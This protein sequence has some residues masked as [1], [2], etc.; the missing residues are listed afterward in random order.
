MI[1][2]LIFVLLFA[3]MLAYFRIADKYNIIDKPNQR[4]SHTSIT[5]RGGG[6]VFPVAMLLFY[7]CFGM[8]SGDMKW[9]FLLAGTLAI[10]TVSFWD[11]VSSLPNK[12]RISIHLLAVSALLYS[13]GLYSLLPWWG[14]ALTYIVIIGTI[15]AYNFMDGING[16]TGCYSLVLLLSCLYFNERVQNIMPSAYLVVPAIACLVFLFFN[17]RKKAKCFAGDIGSV[18]I[19]FWVIS[20]LAMILIATG[21]FRYVFFLAVYG[22]DAVLT[23]MHRLLLKQNIFEAHRLHFYQ[24]LA[25]ERKMPHLR[26]ASLYALLQAGINAFILFTSFNLLLTAVLVGVPLILLY[27]LKP[28]LMKT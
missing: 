14:I 27:L 17:F 23:I 11:D 28:R 16:I 13:L 25:N 2:L 24:I 18:S 21:D 7:L 1:Y 26:V 3:A 19:G 8:Q 6:I 15:N 5:I 20:V 22:V 4:S 12:V 9:S 10:G